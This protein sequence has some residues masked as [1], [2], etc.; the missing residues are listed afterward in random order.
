MKTINLKWIIIL[1][2]NIVLFQA[3]NNDDLTEEITNNFDDDSLEAGIIEANVTDNTTNLIVQW[4]DLWVSLDQYTVGMRPNTVTRSLAYIHLTGYET[5][6][7]F[8]NNYNSN[9]N[10]FNNF[11]INNNNFEDN[12]DLDLALNTAYAI[13]IDHFM[14]S[15][16][17]GTRQSISNFQD[18]KE[19]E[20]TIGLTTQEI[21]NSQLWGTHVAERVIAYAE[22]DNDAEE[23]IVNQTPNDYVAPVGV[24]LWEAGE[25]EN[26]WFP[27][28]REVRT[29]AISPNQTSSTNFSS[30]L[31]HSTNPN[32]EYYQQMTAVYEATVSAAT[33]NTEQLWIAEFWADDVEGLMISPPGR[34]FSIANQLIEQY[35][36]DYDESLELLLR[37]GLA[38]N[39]AAVSAWDDKYTYNIERP[40][41][42]IREYID[43]DYTTNLSRF[44]DG[45]NPAFP[46]YPSGHAT[47]A[48]AAAGIFIDF[49]GTDNINFTDNTYSDYTNLTFNGTPRSFTSFS[50][51]A[52]ENALSRM[53]LGVH[54]EQD[55]IEGLRLGYE[56]SD[57]VN[58]INL[59]GRNN[60]NNN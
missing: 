51:M 28:W 23:Q 18:D 12:V 53:P 29:F 11:N 52:T 49:F 42:F 54:I 2:I 44:I 60:N 24:G 38:L 9:T 37:L 56:V 19:E 58:A 22:T 46:S 43:E 30:V 7:P 48:G 34:H 57:A 55:A 27:Y 3:C 8:M 47:F 6:V 1:C 41:N 4:S 39:D 31:Q 16:E 32:S 36:L 45:V 21:E 59:Q 33:T 20:L 17:A 40:S 13:A 15:L 25:G 50:S 35:D 14:H 10:R 26:A 5:A